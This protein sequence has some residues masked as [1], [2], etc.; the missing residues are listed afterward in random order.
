[1]PIVY[2][3]TSDANGPDNAPILDRPSTAKALGAFRRELHTEGLDGDTADEL[4]LTAGR[5][6]ISHFGLIV[7]SREPSEAGAA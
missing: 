7:D 2:L 6:L 4:V 3:P 5:E 1:M